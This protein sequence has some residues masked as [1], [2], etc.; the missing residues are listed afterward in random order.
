MSTNNLRELSRRIFVKV[1][2]MPLLHR[3][4]GRVKIWIHKLLSGKTA[5]QLIVLCLAF[6]VIFLLLKLLLGLD[7]DF[8]FKGMTTYYYD[9]DKPSGVNPLQLRLIYIVGV[10]FFGGFLV[11]VLTNGVRNSVERFVDGDV[12]YRFDDHILILGYNEIADGVI[13]DVNS[14]QHGHEVVI[15]VENGV[16]EVRER[17][18]GKYGHESNIFVL[19]GNRAN[20]SDLESLYPSHAHEIYIIGENESDCDFKNLD[21]YKEMHNLRDFAKWRSY[22]Y[23]YLQE[24]SSITLINNRRYNNAAMNEIA[25][26]N[27]RLRLYNTDER[28]ARRILVDLAGQW[29]E[30]GLNM[31]DGERITMDSDRCVHLVIFGMTSTGEVVAT[32][33]ART[34]HHPNYVTRGIRTR[35]TVID[36][37]FSSNKGVFHG[38]YYDFMEMCHYSIKRIRDNR[39]ETIREHHPSVDR[40]F[41]DVEW[42]FI[43][44]EPD[45]VLLQQQLIGYARNEDSLLSVVVCGSDETQNVSVALG[46]PKIFFDEDVPI[47]LYT[48]SYSSIRYYV[49]HSR[50]DNIVTWG[51]PG[52]LPSHEQIE[53]TAAKR[54]SFLCNQLYGATYESDSDES[55][56]REWDKLPIDQRLSYVTQMA[57][58]PSII[59]SLKNW[60][61]PDGKLEIGDDELEVFAELEHT[62]WAVCALLGG[63]RPLD[64]EMTPPSADDQLRHSNLRKKFFNEY[65]T[66][67]KGINEATKA[68][69]RDIIRIYL[70]IMNRCQDS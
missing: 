9:P 5:Y 53:E 41:L 20:R 49:E 46:L 32:T 3:M 60:S 68:I 61:T 30:R 31:R 4:M 13:R 66:K 48:R 67:Y 36:N 65:I 37:D 45:E 57:A 52:D 38:R 47:W 34:C 59:G 28:W 17:I 39:V 69:N 43:E 33:A 7:G 27:H 11:M 26:D 63:Y 35:I 6:I 23:L 2:R 70:Q 64:G 29:P 42:E 24:Q 62:R 51:M 19:H 21:C 16:R 10:A 8:L 14:K 44:S 15:V 58:V 22:I 56:D 18:K 12:R 55:I 54:L 40:D 50:Y 1:E 25:D